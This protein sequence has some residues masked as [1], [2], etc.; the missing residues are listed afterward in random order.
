MIEIIPWS[1]G[2]REPAHSEGF[3]YVPILPL[4]VSGVKRA[5]SST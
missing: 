2:H 3:F 5:V 4:A 1:E